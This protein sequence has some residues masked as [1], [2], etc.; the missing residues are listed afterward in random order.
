VFRG[1]AHLSSRDRG[2]AAPMMAVERYHPRARLLRPQW[3][4]GIATVLV[5]CCDGVVP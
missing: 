5:R 2:F 1:R 3:A 4:H